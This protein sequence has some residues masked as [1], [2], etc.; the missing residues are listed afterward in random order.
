M[1]KSLLVIGLL[2]LALAPARAGADGFGILGAAGRV[3]DPPYRYVALSPHTRHPLTVIARLDLRDTT[4]DRWWYLRGT[5]YIPAVAYD[6]SPGGLSADGKLVLSTLPQG[7]P[8]K[9]TGFAI[10]DTRLFLRHPHREKGSPRHA[11]TR[12]ALPGAYSFDA[13]SPDGSLIYL[14]HSFFDRRRRGRYEVRALH[15]ATGRLKPRPIVDPDEPDERM[16]GSPVSR[17][18]SLDGRWAY[19]LYTGSEETFLHALD[20]VRGRAV[21]VDL[22]Q[23]E[24]L[25]EPFQL[26]LKLGEEGRRILVSSR[27]RRDSPVSP[28]L[29]IDTETFEVHQP[30]WTW[31]GLANVIFRAF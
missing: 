9:R 8:P 2:L 18:A 20:T 24:D 28:L 3:D 21:C 17:V 27:D 11:I 19:T 23:L 7:Y 4:V 14:I 5:Y 29:E 15:T 31:L 1:R 30:L 10:L 22:P 16:Q 12:I 6:G 25:R 13:I 26:R